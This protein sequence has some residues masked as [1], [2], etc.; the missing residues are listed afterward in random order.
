M[1]LKNPHCSMAIGVELRSSSTFLE[2]H[3]QW[4]H[5]HISAKYLFSVES[6]RKKS[7]ICLGARTLGNKRSKHCVRRNS[8]AQVVDISHR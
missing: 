8:K 3:Q 7:S 1:P 5:L 4:W 2:I 6:I